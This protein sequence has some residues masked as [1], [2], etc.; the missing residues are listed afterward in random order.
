METQKEITLGKDKYIVKKMALRKYAAFLEV[1]GNLPEDVKAE[2]AGADLED[3]NKFISNLPRLI[4]K[5]FPQMVKV[6]SIA[7]D[8]PEEKLMDE[9]GLAEAAIVFQTIFELNDFLAVKNAVVAAFKGVKEATA[10]VAEKPVEEKVA[11]TGL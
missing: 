9:Y 6:L 7:S 8:V 4:S 3:K 2:I 11:K 5:A 1:I 10:T